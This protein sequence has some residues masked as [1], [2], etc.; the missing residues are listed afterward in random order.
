MSFSH[1][2]SD[3][4]LSN[5]MISTSLQNEIIIDFQKPFFTNELESKKYPFKLICDVD[6]KL[7]LLK[8]KENLCDCRNIVEN[9]SE[10]KVLYHSCNQNCKKII[11]LDRL[12]CKDE[13]FKK[14]LKLKSKTA[15]DYIFVTSL[16]IG[17]F[18]GSIR[19][20]VSKLNRIRWVALQEIIFKEN[21]NYR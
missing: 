18:V 7:P 8:L 17:E 5:L 3:S 1:V 19:I 4:S 14:Q 12:D 21:G 15:K 6:E 16:N 13:F 2:D 20:P 11:N 10:L 9:D